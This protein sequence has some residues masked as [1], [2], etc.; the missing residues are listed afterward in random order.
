MLR[1]R[2]HCSLREITSASA[3][4][5]ESH[6]TDCPVRFYRDQKAL[7]MPWLVV[8]K[9]C[10]WLF[11][12]VNT[13]RTFDLSISGVTAAKSSLILPTPNAPNYLIPLVSSSF[14]LLDRSPWPLHPVWPSGTPSARVPHHSACS[15]GSLGCR[16]SASLQHMERPNES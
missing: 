6:V 7:W 15:G 5:S 13:Y 4:S 9:V 1:G 10:R 3:L 2:N 8:V 11:S 16:M 14:S 12:T